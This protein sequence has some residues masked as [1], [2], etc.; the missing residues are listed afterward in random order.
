MSHSHDSSSQESCAWPSPPSLAAHK[1]SNAHKFVDIVHDNKTYH[2]NISDKLFI[3]PQA[4]CTDNPLTRKSNQP[5]IKLPKVN[6]KELDPTTKETN[7]TECNSLDDDTENKFHQSS[8]YMK[9]IEKSSEELDE[10]IE[11]D[12][13]EEDQAWLCLHNDQNTNHQ[14]NNNAQTCT[15]HVTQEH[16][17]F[18]MDRFEKESYFES[19]K[20]STKSTSCKADKE[21]SS[22]DDEEQVEED[23]LCCICLDGECV[24]S[25]AILFC[26]MCNLAVHQDCYGVPYIPEGQWLCRRCMQS[27][28]AAV[29]CCLCPNRYGAFKQCEDTTSTSASSSSASACCTKWAHMVCAIWIPEVHFANTVFLEPIVGVEDIES[30]R[31]KLTCYIC[32]KKNAGACI[33][34]DNPSCY[35]AFHVTC[36]QQAG[37]YMALCEDDGETDRAKKKTRG[38]S[39]S[40]RRSVSRKSVSCGRKRVDEDA[41]GESL[42]GASLVSD[43][44]AEEVSR[45]LKRVAYCDAHTPV[46]ILSPKSRASGAEELLK[47]AQKAR[48]KKARKIAA[49][50]MCVAPVVNLPVLPDERLVGILEKANGRFEASYGMH[51]EV[52]RKLVAFWLLKRQARAGVALLRRLQHVPALLKKRQMEKDE[53]LKELREQ[54]FYWQKLRQ[55]LEKARLLME[56][57]RK[58]EKM[59]REHIRMQHLIMRMQL[60]PF[61]L[62]LKSVL[63]KLAVLDKAK[64]FTQPVDK[65]QVPAYYDEIKVPM[66]FESMAK[67]IDEHAYKSFKQF[68]DD[69]QLILANCFQFNNKHDYFYKAGLKLKEQAVPILKQ[70]R[71][72]Y[73]RVGYDAACSGSHQENEIKNATSSLTNII[74]QSNQTIAA[75]LEAILKS[76]ISDDV[77]PEEKLR[78]LLDRLDL[79]NT[80]KNAG[81]RSKWASH[82]KNEI[83]II[84]RKI[85]SQVKNNIKITEKYSNMQRSILDFVIRK[86]GACNNENQNE[87]LLNQNPDSISSMSSDLNSNLSSC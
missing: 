41:D 24:N 7:E 12:M 67:K 54:L 42:N 19:H 71:I 81:S 27:P 8:T 17:E 50:K 4:N 34:C 60:S 78:I 65:S 64:I 22:S 72:I 62:F 66:D 87:N 3:K 45:E 2:L 25:N 21:K 84:K 53:R 68:E 29:Q 46:D 35:M 39:V 61:N 82:L 56:L 40:R 36:A 31:W 20:S 16:F 80:I 55:D 74:N 28:S 5:F 48:V 51:D 15:H 59:K 44:D 57:I 63:E 23:A 6:V 75:D 26:D 37:L 85:A 83:A 14:N 73:E 47:K 70:S 86:Q 1:A 30:A 49:E 18:F 9:Y 52:V 13:D 76:E 38:R 11:Y 32:R 79:A 43:D 77:M 10:E 58:R 69:F 33:Q